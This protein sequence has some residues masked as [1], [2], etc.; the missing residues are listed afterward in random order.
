MNSLTASYDRVEN[1]VVLGVHSEPDIACFTIQRREIGHLRS[2]P[3][4]TYLPVAANGATSCFDY[5]AP[6]NAETLYRAIFYSD[7]GMMI[8]EGFAEAAVTPSGNRHWLKRPTCALGHSPSD[9][10]CYPDA[11]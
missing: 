3:T 8:V 7:H 5:T 1:R 9:C 2:I 10:G 6:L 4:L 11:A